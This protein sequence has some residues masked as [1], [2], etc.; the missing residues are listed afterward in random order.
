MHAKRNDRRKT[1]D[2]YKLS[3][4]FETVM[5]DPR[6]KGILKESGGKMYMSERQWELAKNDFQDSFVNFATCGD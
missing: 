3:E 1:R 5:D 4:R 6:V 2:V